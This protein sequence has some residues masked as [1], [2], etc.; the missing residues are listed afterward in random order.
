MLKNN[1]TQLEMFPANEYALKT[2]YSPQENSRIRKIRDY[3]K[4]IYLLIGFIFIST[5]SFSLGVEKG[6]KIIA[7][8]KPRTPE[9]AQN[10]NGPSVAYPIKAALPPPALK[11]EGAAVLLQKEKP[12][13]QININPAPAYKENF[14][15][16][17][18]SIAKQ[19]NISGELSKLKNKGYN[20]FS[21][22]KGKYAVICVGKFNLKEEAQNN[23]NKIKDNYP[24][25]MIRRL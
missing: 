7:S 12:A 18:A 1:P 25:S 23:L 2:D 13:A 6:K 16:Q 5:I 22:A 8:A 24:G 4:I 19:N 11:Q 3:Q 15:I 14:T 9:L 17:V 21:L 10:P 20:A